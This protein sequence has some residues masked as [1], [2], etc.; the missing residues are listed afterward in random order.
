MPKVNRLLLEAEFQAKGELY[1][2]TKTEGAMNVLAA[3]ID[4]NDDDVIE[5]TTNLQTQVTANA[6]GLSGHKTATELDHPD[7][8]VTTRKIKDKNVTETK[9]GDKAVSRRTI[10]TGAVGKNELDPTL[11]EQTANQAKFNEIDNEIGVLSEDLAHVATK[12]N[13]ANLG[14]YPRIDPEIV[15][16]PRIQRMIDSLNGTGIAFIPNLST[17]YLI[18]APIVVPRG[19]HLMGNGTR[20][21]LGTTLKLADGA[22]CNIIESDTGLT[23]GKVND[24]WHYGGIENLKLVGNKANNTSGNGIYI[25]RMGENS[26]I[27]NIHTADF[28]GS[29]I[30]VE[31]KGT[32]NYFQQIHTF[33]NNRYGV[34]IKDAD[35]VYNFYELSG[36]VNKLGL[37]GVQGGSS[38]RMV[39]VS[40]FGLK[41]ERFGVGSELTHDPVIHLDNIGGGELNIFG[42][43]VTSESDAGYGDAVVKIDT[44]AARVQIHGLT[45]LRYHNIIKDNATGN[46]VRKGSTND[47]DYVPFASN[48]GIRPRKVTAQS[49]YDSLQLQSG[50][51]Y[52]RQ[53]AFINLNAKDTSS[54]GSSAL[55]VMGSDKFADLAS[56]TS[57]IKFIA[58]HGSS[59]F[60]TLAEMW[61]SGDLRFNTASRGVVVTTPDGTKKFRIR[62]DN[63][64]ALVTEQAT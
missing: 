45:V 7:Q 57:A 58:Q 11:W 39:S 12:N 19:V 2:D 63:T 5:K 61:G 64:G 47:Y 44:S 32:P 24:Y 46:T 41:A 50:V 25:Y 1:D 36:D 56:L 54:D 30:L 59:G 48:Y 33:N 9:I 52:S 51:D 49:T 20:N 13:G 35:R 15:D 31:G 62:V 26:F 21:G 6:N 55:I 37:L 29:G 18:N 3:Q 10:N 34:E 14:D 38:P 27:R 43:A 23:T 53:G 60:T 8:S 40:I 4:A 42:G 28:A 16:N 22:N 17:E